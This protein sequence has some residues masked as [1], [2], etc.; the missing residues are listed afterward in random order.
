MTPL[1]PRT[2]RFIRNLKATRIISALLAVEQLLYGL[3][4]IQPG[5][6]VRVQYFLSAFLISFL[7][8]ISFLISKP[9]ET[10]SGLGYPFFEM[11]P[12]ALGMV[13]ALNR[14]FANKGILLNIPTLY[15]AFIYG[16]AVSFLLDYVQSGILYG[17]FA[18][19]SIIMANSYTLLAENVP[20]YA[21]FVV[22][23]GIA[24]TISALNYHYY[25]QE[26]KYISLIEDQNQQLRMVSEQDA[27]TGLLNR[28]KIDSIIS[29]LL[30]NKQNGSAAFTLILFDLDHFKLV[31]DTFGHQR[32]DLLLKE[33]SALV[34]EQL[35]DGESLARW[36]GEE[37]LIL[38]KR[39]G[40]ALA[41]SLR[42][43]IENHVFEQVGK[44]TASFGVSPVLPDD[45]EIKIFRQ[46]DTALYRAKEMGKNRVELFT[47]S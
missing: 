7:C 12:L 25:R 27:L 34:K 24:W 1:D 39:D 21:D 14:M 31:N 4:L 19:A 22:N 26:Q 3:F 9:K 8:F 47:N 44:I 28:R 2:K 37:F 43:N 32:G 17:A 36:G 30:Q 46:V 6:P 45:S 33:L 13:I 40:V 38:T 18:I 23:N 16:G 35:L 10:I 41:E 15:L 29:E 11:L 5:S 42:E 20:F